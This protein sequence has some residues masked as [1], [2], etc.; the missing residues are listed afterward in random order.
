MGRHQGGGAQQRPGGQQ[1]LQKMPQQQRR[2]QPNQHQLATL[3]PAQQQVR[4]VQ[5]Q[6]GRQVVQQQQQQGGRGGLQQQQAAL[7]QQPP[8]QHTQPPQQIL[9]SEPDVAEPVTQDHFADSLSLDDIVSQIGG[10]AAV[11]G[12][13]GDGDRR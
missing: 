13:G 8:Q 12:E 2:V 7:P 5:G 10:A 11:A 9:Q 3:R 6:L 1:A 4:P